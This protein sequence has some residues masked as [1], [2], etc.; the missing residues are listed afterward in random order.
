MGLNGLELNFPVE[1]VREGEAE[2]IVPKLDAY[3]R[4]PWDYAP[5][6]APV[7]YNPAMELARDIAVLALQVYADRR[8]G[9]LRVCEP[10]AGC[11]VR[12]VRFA[13]EVDGVEQVVINDL[14]PRAVELAKKN[15]ELNRLVGRVFVENRDANVLLSGYAAPKMRFDVV[16][17]DPF[18]SPAPYIA[19]SVRALRSGGL[20]AITATD[21]APL[22]GVHPR[23][24]LRKYGG[25]P[26]RTEYCHE[27]AV[28]L[29]LGLVARTAAIYNLGVEPLLS[30]A[31][32]HYLRVYCRVRWGKQ[33]ANESMGNLGY[34]LHCFHCFH[35]EVVKGLA[36]PISETCSECGRRVRVAGPLWA[37]PIFD[38]EFCQQT[39]KELETREFRHKARIGK[40]LR[41]IVEE[42][43]GPA[44]YYTLNSLCDVMQIP[45]PSPKKVVERLKSEAYWA[46]LT[47][48]N[49]TGV[50]TDAKSEKVMDVLRKSVRS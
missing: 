19:S 36:T 4:G 17:L 38:K 43:D 29:V 8:G 40:I 27:L 39:L 22:C 9:S 28:R 42:A 30:H 6:R 10:L 20:L 18:G 34:V 2:I 23:A 1:R 46:S 14:N 12:G 31:T 21:M 33:R 47:H 16:D 45:T 7:F 3:R 37:G 49:P 48:F 41:L 13:L 35:R 32:D 44:T 26:L 50:R 15:V 24:C 5:S 11:G 25:L